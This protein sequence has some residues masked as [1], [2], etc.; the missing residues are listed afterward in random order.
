MMEARAP[1]LL[2]VLVA[3]LL[4]ASGSGWGSQVDSQAQVGNDPPS[5]LAI[6]L[7]AADADPNTPERIEVAPRAGTTVT[8]PVV[9]SAEDGN[10]WRDLAQA[11]IQLLDPQGNPLGEPVTA[12]TKGEP[13]GKKK[14]FEASF[15]MNY[16]DPPGAYKVRLSVK[17]RAN[18]LRTI[19]ATFHYEELLA[20]SLGSSSVSFGSG[21]IGPGASTHAA[22]S[23]VAIRNTGNVVVD[24]ALS[25]TDLTNPEG[26]A[27]ISASRIRYASVADM[28]GERGLATSPPV[29]DANFNL[30]P[31]AT[32]EKNAYFDIHMPTGE[33]QFIPAATY[34]GRL[35]IGAAAEASS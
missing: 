19:E 30:A 27:T 23:T 31:G 34:R 24:L 16:Y 15:T 18:D 10:G 32:A 29:S 35:T 7:S 3:S 8:V 2:S 17:D 9:A 1:V 6:D 4:V 12:P 22:P 25:A 14:E 5:A 21:A 26:D 13:R 20:I 28:A 33:E 11:E